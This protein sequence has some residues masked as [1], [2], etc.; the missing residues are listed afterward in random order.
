MPGAYAPA[1]LHPN[2]RYHDLEGHAEGV[3]VFLAAA[4]FIRLR[5]AQLQEIACPLRF[6]DQVEG[7]DAGGFFD[8]GPVGAGKT[9]T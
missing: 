2:I 8:D 3:E 9:L 5:G 4:N 6:A 1:L 7:G